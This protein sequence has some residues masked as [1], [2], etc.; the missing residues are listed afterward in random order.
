MTAILQAHHIHVAYGG[1]EAVHAVSV[2]VGAGEIATVIGPNGA[3]KTTLLNAL[4]GV[5]PSRG[6]VW[7]SGASV[8]HLGIE[9]RAAAGM[10]LVPESRA[11]FTTA[12]PSVAANWPARCRAGSGRCWRWAAR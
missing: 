11:L 1:I 4:M 12:W 3:G 5:L 9:A 7:F 2:E 8:G 6:D 10:A